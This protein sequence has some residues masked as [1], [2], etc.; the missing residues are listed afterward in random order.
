MSLG[1]FVVLEGGEGSG[2]TSLKPFLEEAFPKAL[3][4]RE[5]GGTLI[6]EDIRQ[7]LLGGTE[8]ID[9][10]TSMFLFNASRVQLLRHFLVPARK[11][12]NL[13]LYDRFDASTYAYQVFGQEN[14]S[15]RS[16][17]WEIRNH[18]G[19]IA[20]PDLYIYLDV[21]V[22][23][24]LRRAA[25]RGNLNRLDNQ[26]DMF[27]YRVRNGYQEFFERVHHVVIDANRPQD[28]VVSEVID[29][30]KKSVSL[31]TESPLVS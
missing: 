9:A 6:G 14:Q 12:G 30:I 16:L 29:V 18:L 26:N 4:A 21:E 31:E 8:D 11:T 28:E 7:I 3:F 19:E 27:H 23:T 1:K 24:G 13:V 17:F 20:L 25:E 10:L 5:P 2:K 22:S 15:L